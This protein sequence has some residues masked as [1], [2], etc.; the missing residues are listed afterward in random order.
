MEWLFEREA[1][2]TFNPVDWALEV[3]PNTLAASAD[4]T[5]GSVESAPKR[6]G[7]AE[8]MARVA[9][10]RSRQDQGNI[11]C[12]SLAQ[13]WICCSDDEGSTM[14]CR[15]WDPER[16]CVCCCWFHCWF[17]SCCCAWERAAWTATAAAGSELLTT[18][19]CSLNRSY[20]VPP[21]APS[22]SEWKRG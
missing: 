4:E 18:W 20:P 10:S 13:P 9:I 1:S 21:V 7:K 5:M 15:T 17:C 12:K 19:P 2:V 14:T 6:W 11:S 16:S 22:N 3:W 8:I